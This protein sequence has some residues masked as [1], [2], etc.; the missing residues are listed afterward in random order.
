MKKFVF[1]LA[2]LAVALV[3]CTKGGEQE[4]DTTPARL[5]S[6]QILKADNA[7]LDK[8]YFAELITPNMVIRVPGG[9]MDKSFKATIKVG[10]F[11]KL[12][13]NGAAVELTNAS[14]KVDFQGKFAV[15]IEVV[16]TKSSKSAAYE[17]KIGK[18]LQIV[19]KKIGS[20]KAAGDKLQ[21]TSGNYVMGNNPKN[22]DVYFA[23][24]YGSPKNV[25]VVKYD[26]KSFSQVGT[27]GITPGEVAISKVCRIAFDSKGTPYLL[28]IGG[29]VASRISLRKFD[30][31]EWV[32]V[33]SGIGTSSPNT[34][35][36]PNIY[37]DAN[38]NPFIIYT[39]NTKAATEY[40][41]NGVILSNNG[42]EWTESL[43]TGMPKYD[44]A[45][46]KNVFYGVGFVKA[47]N[48]QYAFCIGNQAGIYAFDITENSWTTPLVS[49]F[50]PEGEET[51]L[52]GNLTGCVKADGTILMFAAKWTAQA[53]QGY[54]FTGSGFEPYGTSIP[55]TIESNGSVDEDVLYGVNPVTD[56]VVAVM[57]K[58]SAVTYSTLDEN[59][60]WNE[61]VTLGEDAPQSRST[62]MLAFDAKGNTI[63]VY[64][65]KDETSGFEFY[66]IGLEDDILPE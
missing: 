3:S 26:G 48:K 62:A 37:F 50:V 5:L 61:F 53:M 2:A 54:K 49:A 65:N 21:Y 63:V 46:N 47:S 10:E 43:I 45:T 13:V 55:V 40:Y 23:Y 52:P 57:T 25:G 31:S 36:L 24:V 1:A 33:A 19:T 38:D 7:F 29:D 60:R 14:A 51:A 16:N 44:S 11:D 28:T 41:R 17:V 18:I 34:S 66:S 39:G 9:G 35:Y 4:K 8:D 58:S 64:P 6:F 12:Y 59:L 56:E 30:G 27:E 22:G 32:V 15:D 42:G 20:V